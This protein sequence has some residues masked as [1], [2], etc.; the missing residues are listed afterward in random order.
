MQLWKLC[1]C[2]SQFR[3]STPDI[4]NGT[5]TEEAVASCDATPDNKDTD[6]DSAVRTHLS[7]T[8]VFSSMQVGPELSST[9]YHDIIRDFLYLTSEALHLT[10][11]LAWGV[12]TDPNIT[13][14][15][16]LSLT[17]L[18]HIII[19][20][21]RKCKIIS[22]LT[23]KIVLCFLYGAVYCLHHLYCVMLR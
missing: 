4:R 2:C 16:A 12:M 3:P 13:A 8:E 10:I 14:R 1:S 5:V 11:N 15:G 7:L 21:N 17:A 22:W 9:Y 19:M 6:E 18:C 20:S 23:H